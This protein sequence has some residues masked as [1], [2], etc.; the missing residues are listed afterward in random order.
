MPYCLLPVSL[1]SHVLIVLLSLCHQVLLLQQQ[2]L[3]GSTKAS[4]SLP[5]LATSDR[6]LVCYCRLFEVPDIT[7]RDRPG[8][9]QRE[10]FLF[11]DLLLIT[12]LVYSKNPRKH[13]L[14]KDVNASPPT[15]SSSSSST[16]TTTA[17]NN[18]NSS[19]NSSSTSGA[20]G[21]KTT[22]DSMF[23]QSYSYRASYP[24]L[25]LMVK[26]FVSPLHPF[27]IKILRRL[28]EEVVVTFNARNA[29]DR[30]RFV[31]DLKES[32]EEMILMDSSLNYLKNNN[33][34]SLPLD[35]SIASSAKS[36][37]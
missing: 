19:L 29:H 11:N 35:A 37:S 15:T 30:N 28:D 32:I 22:G 6:R 24:L 21:S 33:W 36:M 31:M 23:K 26:M 18:H 10:I 25:G 34:K 20:N 27:G 3:P 17:G 5:Q 8:Q 1:P 13:M 12:K 9:H 4:A 16:L 14:T 2:L 7:R